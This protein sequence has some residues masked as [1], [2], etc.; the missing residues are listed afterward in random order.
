MNLVHLNKLRLYNLIKK[1][2]KTD[3][4]NIYFLIKL[5]KKFLK[6]DE[7]NIYFLII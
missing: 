4:E 7:E 3:E 6:T 1:F 2:L 5:I